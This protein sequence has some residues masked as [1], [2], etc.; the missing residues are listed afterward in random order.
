MKKQLQIIRQDSGWLW[1][2]NE[3][4][5]IR[6][7]IDHAIS[8]EIWN[9]DY[10]ITLK[11]ENEFLY[12]VQD[13]IQTISIDKL[14][15]G[16]DVFDIINVKASEIWISDDGNLSLRLL[17]GRELLVSSHEAFEAWQL[18]TNT[19]I[20][21]ICMPSGQLAIWGEEIDS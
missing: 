8:F 17:T 9:E 20:R 18:T 5:V 13:S 4:S 7:I 19:G 12:K 14:K 11:I 1:S 21:V 2:I 10:R 15:T 3:F 16:V 6:C